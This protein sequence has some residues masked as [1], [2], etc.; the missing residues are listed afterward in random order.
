[1]RRRAW[2]RFISGKGSSLEKF[3]HGAGHESGRRGTENVL[4]IVGLGKACRLRRGT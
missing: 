2:E 3:L 4:E 1:M